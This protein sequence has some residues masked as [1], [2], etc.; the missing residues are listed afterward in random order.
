[1]YHALSGYNDWRIPTLEELCSLLE[2]EKNER[3]LHISPLFK[4]TQSKCLS[5]DR[6]WGGSHQD[7]CVPNNIVNF[8]KGQI[9]ETATENVGSGYCQSMYYYIRAVQSTK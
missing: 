1:M 2:Q 6:F 7:Y 3:G 5:A 4:D 8:R 9:D